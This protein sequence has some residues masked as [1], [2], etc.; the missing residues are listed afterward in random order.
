MPSRQDYHSTGDSGQLRE[1]QDWS[2]GNRKVLLFFFSL[3]AGYAG[4]QNLMRCFRIWNLTSPA[5]KKQR[6]AVLEIF[7]CF[8]K[9]KFALL[10]EKCY[11]CSVRQQL[12]VEGNGNCWTG[13]LFRCVGR[14]HLSDHR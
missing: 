4:L 13:P 9:I 2:D 10:D 8:V 3:H 14:L 11:Q 1:G 5:G 6:A 12:G 7:L